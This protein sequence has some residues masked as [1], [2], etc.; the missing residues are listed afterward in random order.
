MLGHALG[1]IGMPL[2]DF[3][4]LTPDEFGAVCKAWNERQEQLMRDGW[5]RMR[6]NATIGI[7][8]HVKGRV[9]PERLLPFPWEKSKKMPK[10]QGCQK[11]VTKK[12]QH[13]HVSHI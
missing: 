12:I 4:R 13:F 10:H 3:C 2:D 7:Q 1:C 6:M 9:T 5:E 11:S 8:P